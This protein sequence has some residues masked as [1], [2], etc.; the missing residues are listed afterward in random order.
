MQ[1]SSWRKW[2]ARVAIDLV[3]QPLDL[4]VAVALKHGRQQLVDPGDHLLVLV[5]QSLKALSAADD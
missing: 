4:R 5:V 1:S 2:L 3:E